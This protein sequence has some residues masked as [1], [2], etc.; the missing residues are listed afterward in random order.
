MKGL[1]VWSEKPEWVNTERNVSPYFCTRGK[2]ESNLYLATH[3][4]NRMTLKKGQCM[5]AEMVIS[6]TRMKGTKE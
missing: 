2:K 3:D 1:E 5:E 4:P 6:I